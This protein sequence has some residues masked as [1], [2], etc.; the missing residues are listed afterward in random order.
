MSD[1]ISPASA[2]AS[3]SR[4]HTG[5]RRSRNQE[6]SDAKPALSPRSTAASPCLVTRKSTNMSIHRPSAA[7]GVGPAASSAGPASAQ[8]STWCR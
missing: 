1:R 8:A 5:T 4:A 3:S 2:A 7:Y 6:C